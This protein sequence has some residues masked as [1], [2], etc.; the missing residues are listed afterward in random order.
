MPSETRHLSPPLGSQ[1][2][3]SFLFHFYFSDWHWIGGPARRWEE[4]SQN[5]RYDWLMGRKFRLLFID[6]E[7]RVKFLKPFLGQLAVVSISWH[8]PARSFWWDSRCGWGRWWR[9]RY[10]YRR[11][12]Q[13]SGCLGWG[14]PTWSW[15]P[16]RSQPTPGAP[17]S[18]WEPPR[19]PIILLQEVFHGTIFILCFV[20]HQLW[21]YLLWFKSNYAS[22]GF[23]CEESAI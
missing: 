12:P 7:T 2:P 8:R 11:S 1:Q 21:K 4:I 5:V 10:T 3:H 15:R 17:A 19:H 14:G 23:C 18:T 22:S 16:P 13:C 20:C 9:R 6:V